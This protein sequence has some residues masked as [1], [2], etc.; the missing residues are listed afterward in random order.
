MAKKTKTDPRLELV[1]R[2]IDESI[3][4]EGVRPVSVN[5]AMNALLAASDAWNSLDAPT[6]K[7]IFA[8]VF[9]EPSIDDNRSAEQRRDAMAKFVEDEH[10][11]HC[12]CCAKRRAA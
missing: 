5:E 11:A 3:Q 9:N 7:K 6:M 12:T 10:A 4:E 2:F 8:L 1:Y